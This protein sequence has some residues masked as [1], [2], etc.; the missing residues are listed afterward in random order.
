MKHRLDP[1]LRPR[2]VADRRC[3]GSSA[4][5]LGDWALR[6]LQHRW[7]P[8]G[9]IYPV[10]PGRDELQGQLLFRYPASPT[11]PETFRTS[12][13]L[14]SAIQRRRSGTGRCQLP[15]VYQ[16]PSFMSSRSSSGQRHGRRRCAIANATQDRGVPD[17][18][19]LRR[20]LHGFL[21]RPRP[22]LD[23][24]LRQRS[25]HEAPG[26]IS[27]DQP[28]RVPECPASSTAIAGRVSMSLFPPAMN[29]R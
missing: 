18:H 11:L 26:N 3:V 6:N 27:V 9:R 28:L 15:P 10:N 12:W 24:W 14:P 16:P 8:K 23:L 29:S 22:R 2:S 19:G 17:M 4:T 25:M 21:Q 1:L 7:L 20:E 13:C 5:P